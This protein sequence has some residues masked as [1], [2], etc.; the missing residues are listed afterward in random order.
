MLFLRSAA[1]LCMGG[2]INHNTQGLGSNRGL[3]GLFLFLAGE[4]GASKALKAL[5][6]YSEVWE[7][8]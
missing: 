3:A 1:S 7:S 4:T 2:C 6:K 5:P 8:H